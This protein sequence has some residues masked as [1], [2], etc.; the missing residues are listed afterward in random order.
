VFTDREPDA[1]W[2]GNALNF[3]ILEDVL[4]DGFLLESEQ[5]FYGAKVRRYQRK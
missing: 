2:A 4:S 3:F 1:E 5:E